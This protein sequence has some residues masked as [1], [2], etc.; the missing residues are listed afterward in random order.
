MEFGIWKNVSAVDSNNEQ[1][2]N[3][4]LERFW[5]DKSVDTQ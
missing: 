2:S 3:A 1:L 5:P 4:I